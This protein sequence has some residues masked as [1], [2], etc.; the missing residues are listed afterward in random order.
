MR[1]AGKMYNNYNINYTW[2]EHGRSKQSTR[3]LERTARNI[4]YKR[5]IVLKDDIKNR[6]R[7]S[8]A[9]HNINE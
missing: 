4:H 7:E 8:P 9:G 6:I 3:S 1:P 2:G 5:F